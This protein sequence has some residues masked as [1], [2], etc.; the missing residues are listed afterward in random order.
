[1]ENIELAEFEGEEA[2]MRITERRVERGEV[3]VAP[4]GDRSFAGEEEVRKNETGETIEQ[5]LNHFRL[6]YATLNLKLR[7]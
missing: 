3:E 5:I 2:E 7:R 6:P 4:A 1:M